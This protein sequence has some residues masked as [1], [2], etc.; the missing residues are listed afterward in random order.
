LNSRHDYNMTSSEGEG[1]LPPRKRSRTSK[2][3]DE[4]GNKKARGRPRVDTQDATAADV[5]SL[6]TDLHFES[7]VMDIL[8]NR[9]II[10][11]TVLYMLTFC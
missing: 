7:G 8:P 4:A 9:G 2:D 10:F 1:Q 6:S 11:I 5:S 3:S